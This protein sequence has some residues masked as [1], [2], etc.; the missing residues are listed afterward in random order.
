MKDNNLPLVSIIM[1]VYNGAARFEKPILSIINQTYTN[2][3]FIICDDGSSD[4][5]YEELLK[6]QERD[7]R[8]LVIKNETNSGL[9]ASLNHCLRHA[10]G[11]YVARM[12]DD[13]IS[14][15]NRLE[16]EV[17]FLS[18]HPDFAI[19][20]TGYRLMDE[21][22]FWGNNDSFGERTAMDI[23][24]G[25]YFAHPTVMI[26][27]NAYTEVGGYSTDPKIG[28][29]EDVDLWCK[30]YIKGY[31]GYVMNTILYDYFESRNSM[32]RR[33]YKHRVTEFKLKM[34][35]RKEMGIPFFYSLL[36]LKTLMVGLLPSVIIKRIHK[37]QYSK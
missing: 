28:R 1:G 33:K 14:H 3:E 8:I 16:E 37:I 36:A 7:S 4:D 5:S 20:A 13:D 12:D 25:R 22:G 2:W 23:Y 30:M 18:K 10:K 11:E 35:Y 31:K 27:K 9:S 29:M 19:V 34:K 26:R 17:K 24:R 21:E 6:F 32:Q 15:A